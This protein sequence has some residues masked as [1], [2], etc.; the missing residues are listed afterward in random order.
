MVVVSVSVVFVVIAI[1]VVVMVNVTDAGSGIIRVV[2][3]TDVAFVVTFDVVIVKVV[4]VG[5]FVF[6]Q[7]CKCCNGSSAFIVFSL[8]FFRFLMGKPKLW[9]RM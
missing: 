6:M 9:I 8:S 4:M 3:V 1:V 5:S 7:I 2:G